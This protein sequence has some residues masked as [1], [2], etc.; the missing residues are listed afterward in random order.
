MSANYDGSEDLED[1]VASSF[2][3]IIFWGLFWHH[4]ETHICEKYPRF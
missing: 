3:A 4:I 1:E 2:F